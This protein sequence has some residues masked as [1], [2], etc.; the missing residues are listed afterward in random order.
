MELFPAVL[1]GGP[2]NSGKSVLIYSLSQALRKRGVPHYVLRAAPD[3]EGDW[4]LE[5]EVTQI[6]LLRVK[7]PFDARWVDRIV[8][9]IQNRHLPLLVDVGGLPTPEQERILSAAT[10]AILLTRDPALRW[11]WRRRFHRYG[12]NLVA[13][14][15]SQLDGPSRVIQQTPVLRGVITGL[16]RGHM[17][18][19]SVFEA[20]VD[21]IAALFRYEAEELRRYHLNMAPAVD[22]VIELDRLARMLGVRL[23][24]EAPRWAP[25]DLPRVLE[26]LPAG[27]PLALYD[28][29]PAWLYAALAVHALPSPLFQFDVRLGWIEPPKLRVEAGPPEPSALH[30]FM[31]RSGDLW[32]LRVTMAHSYLEH[33]ELEGLPV[34]AIPTDEGLVID[35]KLPL[36]LWTALARAY[37]GA[38]AVAVFEPR[39]SEAI[40]IASR[41]PVSPIGTRWP[42]EP[43]GGQRA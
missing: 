28:R 39:T 38:R 36:W 8:R 22:L 13:D 42:V 20:L 31:E 21:R 7:G 37:A 12:L 24:G 14:L 1:I 5:T 33:E 29:A 25:E 3:G 16:V 23:E 4:F 26:S 19:G 15:D 9:D 32:R 11:E 27:K 18:E 40:V 41:D 10:H 2:P 35:G 30:F 34:P 6:R 17:A 43:V